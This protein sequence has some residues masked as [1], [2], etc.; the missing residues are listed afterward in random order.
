MVEHGDLLRQPMRKA[1]QNQVFV[2]NIRHAT[3]ADS[4]SQTTMKIIDA[5][6]FGTYF[7]R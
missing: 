1:L 2:L 5:A 7:Q 3:S 6:R 4:M